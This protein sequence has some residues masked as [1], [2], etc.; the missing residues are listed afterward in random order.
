MWPWLGLGE[1]KVSPTPCVA[2]QDLPGA[3]RIAG[4]VCPILPPARKQA[5]GAEDVDPAL[6]PSS[7]GQKSKGA[8]CSSWCTVTAALSPSSACVKQGAGEIVT[9]RGLNDGFFLELLLAPFSDKPQ[10]DEMQRVRYH[11]SPS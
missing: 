1:F 8:V 9:P 6:H 4:A 7:Q 10:Q 5:V 11:R 3:G 2:A